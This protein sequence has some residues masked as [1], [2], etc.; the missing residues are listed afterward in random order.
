MR[1]KRKILLKYLTLTLIFLAIWVVIN[2]FLIAVKSTS[3]FPDVL[4]FAPKLLSALSILLLLVSLVMLVVVLPIRL[5][6]LLF[7]K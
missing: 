4:S 2:L 6:I 1:D 5:L 7:K 3:N